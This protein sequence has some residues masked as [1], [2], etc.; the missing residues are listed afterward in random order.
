[1]RASRAGRTGEVTERPDT[2]NL[3]VSDTKATKYEQFS[4]DLTGPLISYKYTARVDGS[5][6]ISV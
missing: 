6:T 5:L 1:M 3:K 2:T 4:T